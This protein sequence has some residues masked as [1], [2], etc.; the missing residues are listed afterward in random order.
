[1]GGT[2]QY[3]QSGGFENQTFK[4]VGLTS[5]GIKILR[6]VDAENSATPAHSNTPY[7]MYASKDNQKGIIKQISVYGR[8][9]GRQKIK[10]IDFGHEHTNPN[11][12]YFS[13]KDIHVQIYDKNGKRSNIARR[14]SKKEKRIMMMALYGRK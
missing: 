1:M 10:D 8:E 12:L 2:K 14:P 6:K 3:L 7:T 4:Q 13:K 11:G 9:D 5:N